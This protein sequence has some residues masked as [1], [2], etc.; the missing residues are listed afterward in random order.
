MLDIIESPSASTM[1]TLPWL[2]IPGLL[3]PLYLLAHLAIFVRLA[4]E[5]HGRI[6][7][8]R[9]RTAST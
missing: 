8:K 1:G 3:V 5:A 6:G 4:A 9:L 2:L 7:S